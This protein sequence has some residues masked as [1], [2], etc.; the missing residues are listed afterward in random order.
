[1]YEYIHSNV[2]SMYILITDF[3]MFIFQH[4]FF[5][6]LGGRK[7][8]NLVASVLHHIVD[9]TVSAQFSLRGA[10][11][12]GISKRPFDILGLIPFIKS[13]K[14]MFRISVSFLKD[15]ATLDIL[16]HFSE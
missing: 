3:E 2:H 5:R 12:S 15:F 11:R 4:V 8:R 10:K 7:P 6:R 9:D 14:D 13:K 1:M 16:K